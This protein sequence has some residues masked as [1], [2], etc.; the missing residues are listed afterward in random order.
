M[1]D[2]FEWKKGLSSWRQRLWTV[3]DETPSLDWLL[4]T[5]RPHLVRRLTPWKDD[6]PENVWL[7]TTVENQRWVN[8]RL[9]H[10]SDIPAHTRFLSCEPLLGEIDLDDWLE[11][12]TV[13]W[14]IAGGESG[15]KARPS[16]P[17]WFYAVRD[18]CITHATPFH[19][20]Q[21]GE[22][23]PTSAFPSIVPRSTV[24]D[25]SYST[26]MGRFGKKASGR[27]LGDRTWDDIPLPSMKPYFDAPT[28]RKTASALGSPY[29]NS[30]FAFERL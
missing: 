15:P 27:I 23:A 1:A 29:S 3:I 6:W 13:H 19:F 10:L 17:K 20:K 11:R 12:K 28:G 30:F 26:P 24:E 8:K 5:K 2:V 4:L 22:W 7:G 18:Q 16:D 9:P 14:V 21:W 25:G